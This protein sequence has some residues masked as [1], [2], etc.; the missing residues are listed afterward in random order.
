MLNL[1][2]GK[3]YLNVQTYCTQ[4][5]NL[6]PDFSENMIDVGWVHTRLFALARQTKHILFDFQITTNLFTL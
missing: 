4:L 3:S 1:E 5:K 6:G 2:Q